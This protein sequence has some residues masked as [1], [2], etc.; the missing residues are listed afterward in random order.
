MS[1]SKYFSRNLEE[2]NN[3]HATATLLGTVLVYTLVYICNE[4]GIFYVEAWNMRISEIIMLTF[5]VI[6]FCVL[7]KM[8][9]KAKPSIKMYLMICILIITFVALVFLNFHALLMIA[10]PLLIATHY[11]SKS[12]N[13][14][15]FV[16]TLIIVATAP[17]IAYKIG[18]LDYSFFAWM[19]CAVEP[20]LREHFPILRDLVT[21]PEIAPAEGILLFIAFPNALILTGFGIVA[22][23]V[24]NDRSLAQKDWMDEVEGLTLEKTQAEEIAEAKSQFLSSVSH[25]IRTPV[26]AILGMNSAI[27]RESSNSN[28]ISYTED[29]DSAG[30]L[31]LR[32]V[33]DLMD[34]SKLEAAKM[35]L[36]L[37]DYS[38]SEL[39]YS[40]YNLV[41]KRAIDKNLKLVLKMDEGMPSV[42]HG[43]VRRIEQII[44]NLLDNA[45]KYT[46]KGRIT[47]SMFAM[48]RGVDE[49]N[50]VIRVSDTGI[51]IKEEDIPKIFNAFEKKAN[52][53]TSMANV[54]I[55][56][57]I[58][59]KLVN[60]MSGTIDVKSEYEKGSLFTVTIPQKVVDASPVGALVQSKLK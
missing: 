31:L 13:R 60:M 43:D 5:S 41:N 54:G 44:T 3:L 49:I 35:Q 17:V 48:N 1:E 25:E 6:P 32:L 28:V 26:N 42:L 34:Y 21:A 52:D 27:Q 40:C 22:F 23:K 18:T 30:K 47:F 56:L 7:R 11:H 9:D 33:N 10:Y 2:Q 15:A 8:R 50:M 20:G 24:R 45:I 4:L 12:V 29:I 16:G 39:A 59:D 14:L 55:G 51:G 58:T 57:A 37:G 36:V 46:Q 38:V 53:E 19:L